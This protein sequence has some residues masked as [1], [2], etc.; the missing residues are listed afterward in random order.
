MGKIAS[1][2]ADRN[3]AW[4]RSLR[5][6][7]LM[8][9]AG[10]EARFNCLSSLSCRCSGCSLPRPVTRQPPAH[11]GPS[12]NR[13]AWIS[14][15]SH[16]PTSTP[17]CLDAIRAVA[18]TFNGVGGCHGKQSGAACGGQAGKAP[19]SLAAPRPSTWKT[20]EMEQPASRASEPGFGRSSDGPPGCSQSGI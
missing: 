14:R 8:I 12:D 20:S 2:R 11:P 10:I 13:E 3:D 17:G 7:L 18:A 19:W 16:E 6:P 5:L 1:A 9:L 4:A 15:Q